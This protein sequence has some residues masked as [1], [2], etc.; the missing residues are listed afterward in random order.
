MMLGETCLKT[1]FFNNVG[2][3]SRMR[4]VKFRSVGFNLVH[5]YP[6]G[7]NNFARGWS[8]ICFTRLSPVLTAFEDKYNKAQANTHSLHSKNG[9]LTEFMT[10]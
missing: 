5:A 1:E 2:V 7:V 6:G 10:S 3:S 9:L 4:I 8:L